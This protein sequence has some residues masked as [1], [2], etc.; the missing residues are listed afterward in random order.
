MHTNIALV[1]RIYITYMLGVP[2]TDIGECVEGTHDCHINATCMDTFGSY[3]C[4][5]KEGFSG[6]GRT[7][8]SKLVHEADTPSNNDCKY[9]RSYK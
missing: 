2:F 7:C 4:A 1:T 3:E 9:V 5:C 8:T 6:D